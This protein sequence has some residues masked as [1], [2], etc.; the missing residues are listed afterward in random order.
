MDDIDELL[1]SSDDEYDDDAV[2]AKNLVNSLGDNDLGAQNA[3]FCDVALL[4][5]PNHPQPY[6]F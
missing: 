1:K 2:R 4:S 3:F 6:A 5:R